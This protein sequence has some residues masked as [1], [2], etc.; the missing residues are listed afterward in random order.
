MRLI[1]G[2]PAASMCLAGRSRPRDMV[3]P[4]QEP[5]PVRRSTA[6]ASIDVAWPAVAGSTPS[7]VPRLAT[8]GVAPELP[9]EAVVAAPPDAA[10]VAAPPD[11]VVAEPPLFAVVAEPPLLEL[12]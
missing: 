1:S 2:P 12:S 7:N 8:V 5:V 4:W 11:A 9:P 3:L 6:R 10:V